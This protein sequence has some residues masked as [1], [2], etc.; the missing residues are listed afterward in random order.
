MNDVRFGIIGCGVIAPC[1]TYG[2]ENSE[3]ARLVA[4][5]DVVK[6]KAKAI[7][8][9]NGSPKVY[10]NYKKLLADPEVDAVCICTP[11]GLH[12]KI[13]IDAAKAGKHVLSEKP[14]DITL[15][16]IDALIDAC[17]KANVKLGGIFQRRT[18]ENW[19]KVRNAVRGGKLGKMVL[20]DA[21]IKYYRSQEYYDSGDWRGTWKLDGGG[22]LMNQG[23]HCIDLLN[24]IMGP[25]ESIYAHAAPLVRNIEVEDTAVAAVKFKNGAFGVIECTTSVNPGLNHRMEFHGENGSIRIEGEQIIDWN[26]PDD[27]KPENVDDTKDTAASDPTNIG[28]E[29]HRILIQD[30]VQAIQDDRDPMVTGQEA[31]K[32]VELILAIYKS[33]RTGKPITLPL[34]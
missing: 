4:V 13:G 3:G 27:G 33:S 18:S 15:K 2:I 24:W 25:I 26:V 6:E 20:G 1:H 32:A 10:T 9:E 30:F 5:C 28:K 19:I 12:A 34:K 31:R 29:G 7:S 14:I 8:E 11:S 16:N 17:H 22:A 23:V 21:Y